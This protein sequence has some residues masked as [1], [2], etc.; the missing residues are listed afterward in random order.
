M[1][2]P[3]VHVQSA[4]PE[5]E[6][7]CRKCKV[8]ISNRETRLSQMEREDGPVGQK[9]VIPENEGEQTQIHVRVHI[10]RP[11]GGDSRVGL[12]N[13][14]LLVVFGRTLCGA[15]GDCASMG[16]LMAFFVPLCML[17]GCKQKTSENS[18]GAGVPLDVAPHPLYHDHPSLTAT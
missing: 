8:S 16:F 12:G 3:R 14:E 5:D 11:G 17:V 10:G 6:G 18:P 4:S 15:L 13:Q 2:D 9:R 7:K 1:S